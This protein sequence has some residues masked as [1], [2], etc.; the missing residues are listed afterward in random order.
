MKQ[1]KVRVLGKPV[2]I[3]HIRIVTENKLQWGRIGL[4]LQRV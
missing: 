2:A 4:S 1:M 3:Y